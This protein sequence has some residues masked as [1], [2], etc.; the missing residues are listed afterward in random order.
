MRG[1][2][3]QT[4]LTSLTFVGPD[5][6]PGIPEDEEHE[7]EQ[8]LTWGHEEDEDKEGEKDAEEEEKEEERAEQWQ[9]FPKSTEETFW[10]GGAV[11]RHQAGP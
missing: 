2:E 5:A 6:A 3:S 10:G 11:R 7:E 1:S 9:S 4:V 8:G